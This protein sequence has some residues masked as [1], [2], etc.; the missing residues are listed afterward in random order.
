MCNVKIVAFVLLKG[1][2]GQ[3]R[4]PVLQHSDMVESM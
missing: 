4:Q 2:A 1:V 3:H